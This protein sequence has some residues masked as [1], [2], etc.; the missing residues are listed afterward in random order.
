M[1]GCIQ[2]KPRI[3]QTSSDV[4]WANQLPRHIPNYDEQHF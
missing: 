3:I 2:N 4:L 1:E